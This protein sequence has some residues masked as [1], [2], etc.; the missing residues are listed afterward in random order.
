[1]KDTL[2]LRLTEEKIIENSSR[3]GK[4]YTLLRMNLQF[5]STIILRLPLNKGWPVNR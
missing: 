4:N 5:Y 2:P 3:D 1:M